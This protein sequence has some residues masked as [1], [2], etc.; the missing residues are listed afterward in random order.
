[1]IEITDQPAAQLV[2]IMNRI[3]Q[4]GMTTLS[5]GNL[6]L[7]DGDGNI[8]IT[9]AGIDKGKLSPDDMICVRVDGGVEGS[10]RP[11]SEL[12]FHQAI[13]RARPDVQ[14]I[15]H[16]HPPATVAFSIS[17]IPPDTDLWPTIR[18]ICGSVGYAPY[19]LTGSQALGQVIAATFADG[20]DTVMLENHGAVAAGNT[21]FEAFRRLEALD[22]FARAYV[23]ARS[24]ASTMTSPGMIVMDSG[25]SASVIQ[26]STP[27]HW[28]DRE[29]AL[30]RQLVDIARRAY[31]RQLLLSANGDLSVRIDSIGFLI[32]PHGVDRR[33][34][35]P[36]G[37]MLIP[38]AR[39]D[40][41][42]YPSDSI[43]M[44]HAIYARHPEI[45]AIMLAHPPNATAF[46]LA[47][48]AFDT[49]TIPESYFMLRD[50]IKLPYGLQ[51][52]DG[53][54]LADT[55]S[56]Q[57]PVILIQNE[58]ILVT[59]KDLLQALDRLE[60]AE[61]S[62]R[63]LISTTAIGPVRPIG[64]MELEELRAALGLV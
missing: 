64:D 58:G 35:T 12:P 32:T 44:H 34:L 10:H 2:A 13:Y 41:T 55:I 16:A 8:W 7:K 29:L 21:L 33:H 30:S 56:L 51:F 63:S 14:A 48:V 15:A 62:A 57:S 27:D 31:D 11:S 59:G 25:K 60:V 17:R 20:H 4:G 40:K 61:Y 52:G 50:I 24:L 47:D 53:E 45:G 6:S 19:A 23:G 38:D 18:Q 26:E 36:E 9:P 28:S 43:A 46:S 54:Q 49:R 1:L 5:G 39:F 22:F 37:L 3:Y 42:A